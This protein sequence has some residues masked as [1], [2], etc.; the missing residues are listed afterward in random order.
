MPQ[1]HDC[2]QLQQN[3]RGK[4][5]YDG[6]LLIGFG[7]PTRPEEIRPFL[8]NVLRG[9]PVP[10][11]RLEDAVHHYE[12]VGGKSPF[13]ELTFC[14]ARALRELLKREGPDLPVYVGM[15]NW[16]PFLPDT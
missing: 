15:R 9:R 5:K 8:A 13:N 14:Q 7:G 11:E 6:V 3:L 16:H 2:P 1:A 10:P 12:A 4:M